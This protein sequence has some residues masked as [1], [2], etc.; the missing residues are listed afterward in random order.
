[1]ISSNIISIIHLLFKLSIA[2]VTLHLLK[3]NFSSHVKLKVLGIN[4][5]LTLSYYVLIIQL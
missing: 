5:D 3:R 1:M 4:G 2:R